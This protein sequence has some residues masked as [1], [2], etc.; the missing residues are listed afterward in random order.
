[1]IRAILLLVVSAVLFGA[2]P[3]RAM[4]VQRV[5]SP[6]G[7]E[8]WLIEDHT[9]PMLAVRFAFRGGSALDPVGKEGLADMASTLLDEGAG[10][11]GSQA[12]QRRLE[13]LAVTLRFDAGLDSFGGRM[14]TL[15]RTRDDA[16]DLL[17]LAVSAPRFDPEPVE[18]MRAQLLA[19][20]RV[21]SEDPDTLASRALFKAL[22]PNDP[23]GRPA[24]GTEATIAKITID[25]LRG[26]VARR[27]ARDNLVVGVVGDIAPAEL[28]VLLDRT[29]GALPVHAA[30]WR[31]GP[32]K[33]A[34]PKGVT[35]IAKT[36]PQSSIAF[37]Q[38]GLMRDDPDFY[39]AYVLNHMLGGGGFTSRLYDSIR[40]KRGLAYSVYSVLYPLDRAGIIVG[41]AGTANASA[42]ET[43][44][45]VRAEWKRMAEEGPTAAE[46]DD[47]KRFLTG[48]FPLRFSSSEGIAAMLVG[49][50]LDH[51]GIDYLDR[52][53]ALIE[54]VSLD[55]IRRVAK[56][57]LAPD[58][59]V[60]VVVGEPEGLPKT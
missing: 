22:F 42:G 18:R 21:K 59:L 57:L 14:R 29:F 56:R 1:M 5:V 51:L 16:F 34:A 60:F 55:D 49:L 15:T 8:A 9:N 17:R 7:I 6:G 20:L 27:L 43:V 2:A 24:E 13:S 12:F 31:Q 3:A 48:S 25:D 19:N 40:E 45:L 26:F 35:V 32:V 58:D 53:N 44:S 52:R 11:L 37:A 47:A 10:D 50:Q 41:G 38:R 54:A 39:T 28:S 23:Y 33:P 46:L 30:D 36:V 4:D